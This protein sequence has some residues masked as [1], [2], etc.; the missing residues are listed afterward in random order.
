MFWWEGSLRSPP[1]ISILGQF[2]LFHVFIFMDGGGVYKQ[3]FPEV[4][5]LNRPRRVILLALGHIV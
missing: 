2:L 4:K 5:I 1:L 3:L